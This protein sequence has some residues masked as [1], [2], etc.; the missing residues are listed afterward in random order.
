MPIYEYTCCDCG[1]QFEKFVRS[2]AVMIEVHCP[3]CG[4]SQVK[5]GWSLFGVAG[6]RGSAGDLSA[7]AAGACSSGGT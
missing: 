6:S 2:M 7:S 3:E 4:S 1:T 5:K